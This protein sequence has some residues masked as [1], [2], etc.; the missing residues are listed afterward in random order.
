[1]QDVT[2]AALLLHSYTCVMLSFEVCSCTCTH[3]RIWIPLHIDQVTSGQALCS[4]TKGYKTGPP[5]GLNALRQETPVNQKL[6]GGWPESE[7]KYSE[8]CN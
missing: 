3:A 1:M 6:D 7:E 8:I 5:W 4:K 2:L